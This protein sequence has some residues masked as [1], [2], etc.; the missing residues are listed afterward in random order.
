MSKAKQ[1]AVI[2]AD[3]LKRRHDARMAELGR[4]AQASLCQSHDILG[5]VV[6]VMD[7]QGRCDAQTVLRRKVPDG[8][9]QSMLRVLLRVSRS[10]M[11]RF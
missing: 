6:F 7:P 11:E 1:H 10:I 8:T 2:A 4:R 5:I 9:A 3:L